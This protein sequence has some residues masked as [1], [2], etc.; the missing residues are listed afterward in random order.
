M[1]K[2]RENISIIF[3]LKDETVIA[4]VDNFEASRLEFTF[5]ATQIMISA[6]GT[7]EPYRRCGYARLLFEAL[8]IVAE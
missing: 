3:N 2:V 4:L 8:K 6:V 1:Q 7:E 5:D